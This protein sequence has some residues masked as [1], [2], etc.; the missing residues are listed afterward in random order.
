MRKFK[1]F[2]KVNS[3]DLIDAIDTWK[4]TDVITVIRQNPNALK[5]TA[6][7]ELSPLEYTIRC[8]AK[9]PQRYTII[10]SEIAKILAETSAQAEAESPARQIDLASYCTEA[11]LPWIHARLGWFDK[12]HQQLADAKTLQDESKTDTLA[13]DFNAYPQGDDHPLKGITVFWLMLDSLRSRRIQDTQKLIELVLAIAHQPS[14]INFN[15]G[16]QNKTHPDKGITVFWLMLD[17]LHNRLKQN[18]GQSIDADTQQ[19]LGLIISTIKSVEIDFNAAPQNKTHPDKGTT[20]FW[21]MLDS[22]RHRLDQN[23][24]FID[25]DIQALLNLVITTGEQNIGLIHFTARSTQDSPKVLHQIITIFTM[26]HCRKSVNEEKLT[27]PKISE[28]STAT[29]RL[30]ELIKQICKQQP[31]AIDSEACELLEKHSTETK[32]GL[33]YE[34][35]TAY[36]ILI[37]QNSIA[38]SRFD[39]SMRVI[40]SQLDSTNSNK[41]PNDETLLWSIMDLSL[42]AFEKIEYRDAVKNILNEII[43]ICKQIPDAMDFNAAS[44]TEEGNT[45]LHLMTRI[46]SEAVNPARPDIIAD[47]SPVFIELFNLII[48]ICEER[49][50]SIDFNACHNNKSLLWWLM[51]VLSRMLELNSP[52]LPP[53]CFKLIKK[54]CTTQLDS[55]NFAID[56][57]E[58]SDLSLFRILLNALNFATINDHALRSEIHELLLYICV[59]HSFHLPLNTLLDD[60]NN[61]TLTLLVEEKKW[62]IVIACCLMKDQSE[63][64]IILGRA[65]EIIR[66]QEPTL[67]IFTLKNEWIKLLLQ[68][69]KTLSSNSSIVR[70]SIFHRFIKIMFELVPI[71]DFHCSDT[72]KNRL[73]FAIRELLPEISHE[74]MPVTITVIVTTINSEGKIKKIEEK[75]VNLLIYCY[76][77]AYNDIS[78]IREKSEE[79]IL[80]DS[81]L[82]SGIFHL[83]NQYLMYLEKHAKQ[84]PLLPVTVDTVSTDLPLTI[85]VISTAPL[86]KNEEQQDE[87]GE[88]DTETDQSTP[89]PVTV[90]A[91]STDEKQT[92]ESGGLDTDTDQ[93]TP[94]SVTV[95]PT[96]TNHS[97]N[98]EFILELLALPGVNTSKSE[99]PIIRN[100]RQQVARGWMTAEGYEDCKFQDTP[101]ECFDSAKSTLTLINETLSAEIQRLRSEIQR[102]TQEKAT[103]AQAPEN[104]KAQNS[105][106]PAAVDRQEAPSS[107]TLFGGPR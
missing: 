55:I 88:P 42:A 100:A 60:Q 26:L 54:I 93:S 96:L 36:K 63:A 44:P 12:I 79:I 40:C 97:H 31:T 3:K 64:N 1:Y 104:S 76:E 89:L 13:V 32:N 82:A 18:K 73:N 58:I 81:F 102:L 37:P 47:F 43:L 86:P 74:L 101:D 57:S 71:D 67:N 19:L 78:M 33:L 39:K 69:L 70:M 15:I 59:N 105:E 24:Q 41:Y 65:A 16:P 75:P 99:K 68:I 92:D 107:P 11:T 85:N 22:I 6:T 17:S 30:F 50:D 4:L 87:N 72:E 8:Y 61:T 48:S 90:N 83:V 46:F 2:S 38:V 25:T 51:N 106:P 34:V 98:Y 77:L 95:N 9:D 10:L 49:F 91:A 23:K 5:K 53:R 45:V 66:R 103:S 29:D 84:H 52:D 35:I 28:I 80:P 20:V 94:L 56:G 14:T 27:D 62:D 7:G 21:L